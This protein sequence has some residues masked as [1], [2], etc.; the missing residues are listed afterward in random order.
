MYKEKKTYTFLISLYI[1]KLMFG[2]SV[3]LGVFKNGYIL[4]KMYEWL[5]GEL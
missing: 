1:L 4:T 2:C 3:I 5:K